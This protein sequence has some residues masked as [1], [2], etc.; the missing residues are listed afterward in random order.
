[1]SPERY[2]YHMS[3][4]KQKKLMKIQT[5]SSTIFLLIKL[6]KEYHKKKTKQF[7]VNGVLPWVHSFRREK[8]QRF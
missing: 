3:V 8:Y 5:K 6:H 7:V 2:R 1:M 4:Q